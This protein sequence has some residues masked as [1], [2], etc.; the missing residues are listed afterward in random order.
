MSSIEKRLPELLLFLFAATIFTSCAPSPYN[1]EY[2]IATPI[3][4][5]QVHLSWYQPREPDDYER[6]CTLVY[7]NDVQVAD[8]EVSTEYLDENLDAGNVYCYRI[9]SYYCDSFSHHGRSRSSSTTCVMTYPLHTVSGMIMDINMGLEDI[10]VTLNAVTSG[11]WVTAA[12]TD[13]DGRYFFPDLDNGGYL[14][15]PSHPALAFTP[16][17]RSAVVFNEDVP[18]QDFQAVAGSQ[19]AT[20]GQ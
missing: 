10:I 3:S 18:D 15:V 14:I 11:G 2:V 6:T 16:S 7:R 9:R 20:G 5:S 19:Q 1:P 4:P 17:S 12:I 8:V 13:A